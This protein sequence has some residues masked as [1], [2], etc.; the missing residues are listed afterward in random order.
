MNTAYFD[1]FGWSKHI[2][3][4]VEGITHLPLHAVS[5]CLTRSTYISNHSANIYQGS[6]GHHCKY[7]EHNSVEDV[8]DPWSLVRKGFCLFLLCFFTY[9]KMHP[10][11]QPSKGRFCLFV[12]CWVLSISLLSLISSFHC[13]AWIQYRTMQHIIFL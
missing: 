1:V 11:F 8:W 4:K 7:L 13:C 10:E 6:V 2:S 5:S 9:V 12:C 3:R